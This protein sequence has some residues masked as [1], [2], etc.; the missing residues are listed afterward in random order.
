MELEDLEQISCVEGMQEDKWSHGGTCLVIISLEGWAYRVLPNAS[1]LTRHT[2]AVQA[3]I[4][5]TLSLNLSARDDWLRD[6][7]RS[8]MVSALQHDRSVTK[9][10]EM[11]TIVSNNADK[12][13]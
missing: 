13:K 7:S 12:G 11:A 1:E 10:R 2:V 3:G 5:R 4:G 9:L 6:H 8:S